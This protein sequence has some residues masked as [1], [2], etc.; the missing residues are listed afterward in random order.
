MRMS[1][2]SSDVCP[3][4]LPELDVVSFC[5]VFRD[6]AGRTV[7]TRSTAETFSS[8]GDTI[9]LD[10]MLDRNFLSVVW[11]KIYRRSLLVENGICFPKLRAYEDSVFSRD[12]ARRARKVLYMKDP[13]Y[14][15]LTRHDS[16]SRAMSI[17]SFSLAAEMIDFE[18]S[19]SEEHTSELQSL[20]RIS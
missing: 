16:T 12:V 20:M 3:S 14:L 15:A 2:W 17:R 13:L 1:D 18:R 5:I 7:A 8:S 4:D 10:A 19:R 11:N 6:P 9:F